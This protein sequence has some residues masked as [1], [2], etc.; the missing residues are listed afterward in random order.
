M[1]RTCVEGVLAL[2]MGSRCVPVSDGLIK[3]A[4]QRPLP[5]ATD[6]SGSDAIEMALKGPGAAAVENSCKQ[7]L[8]GYAKAPNAPDACK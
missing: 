6:P 4:R 3:A 8:A 7:A 1:D 2:D 5:I